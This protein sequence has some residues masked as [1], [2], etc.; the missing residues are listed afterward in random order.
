MIPADLFQE[1]QSN[2]AVQED[3]SV[4]GDDQLN[5]YDRCSENIAR[6]YCGLLIQTQ[7]KKL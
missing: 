1:N 2:Q 3:A 7:T 6:Y 4:T 5:L